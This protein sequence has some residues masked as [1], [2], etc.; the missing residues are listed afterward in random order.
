[1][2]VKRPLHLA[3]FPVSLSCLLCFLQ[4]QDQRFT[5]FDRERAQIMLRNVARDVEKHYYDPKFHG[6]DWEARVRE[7]KA[8][9]DKADSLDSAVSEI[10]AA[11]DSLDDSHTLFFPPPRKFIHE[12]GLRF[13]MIGNRCYVLQVRPGSDADRKGLKPGDQ[14]VAINGVPISREVFWRMGYVYS[15]LHPQTFL[16]FSI[17]SESGQQRNLDV[18]AKMVLSSQI[19]YYL[20]TGILQEILDSQNAWERMRPRDFEKGDEL[21]VV[22]LPRL[23]LSALEV[24]RILGKMRK[25]RGVVMDL[26]GGAGGD[27]DTL[28][29]FVGGLF[30]NDLK[31]Y[32]R[33]GRNEHKAVSVK[34]RHHDAYTGRL[35][36]VV[37]SDSA[38]TVELLARIIQIQRRGLIIGDHTAGTVM[39]MK[40]YMYEAFTDSDVYYGA[41]I[42]EAD[43]VMTD[44]KTLEHAGVEPDILILPTPGDL[45]SGRDPVLAKAATLVGGHLTPEDAG[46]LFPYEWPP[47]D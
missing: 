4:A 27:R 26:R 25:H 17:A 32:D 41:F 30:E 1:M 31:V 18:A 7:A 44:G 8:A 45:A 46:A 28:E 16:R 3:L 37:D 43:L 13:R 14:I 6:I 39:E 9:I 36:I 5:K 29:R 38:S 23:G 33:N 12:F 10:A 2:L 35:A 42:T 24:D 21:L 15:Y 19:K 20:H 11:L 40:R 34:G 47:L 22:K